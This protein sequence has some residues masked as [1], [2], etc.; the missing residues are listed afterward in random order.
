KDPL[1]VL[2]KRVN[3]NQGAW[4][5]GTGF[6]RMLDVRNN[7][8]GD[9]VRGSAVRVVNGEKLDAVWQLNLAC[10]CEAGDRHGKV[11]IVRLTLVAVQPRAVE[12][13]RIV[14]VKAE[15][16]P[17]GGQLSDMGHP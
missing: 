16:E 15:R 11:D 17:L 4:P 9:L 12:P 8:I 1:V 14:G 13:P 5:V 7:L 6:P 3:P 2:V 10:I